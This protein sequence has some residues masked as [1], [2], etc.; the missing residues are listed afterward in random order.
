[1]IINSNDYT[2]KTLGIK[3]S[4]VSDHFTFT[5]CLDKDF[6]TTKR[7][8]LSEFAKLFDPLGWLSPTTF[9]LKSFLQIL[10]MD[11]LSWDETLSLNIL[12]QYGRFRHQ[13]KE[14]EKI[15]LERRVFAAP[16]SSSLELHVFC[17]A[18]TTAYA[19]FVYVREQMDDR[20]HTQMLTAK[21]RVAPI[22]TL[23]VP[24]LEI[25][26]ALLGAQLFQAVK[27]AIND[28][29]FPNPKVFAWTN[30]QVTLA[31]I[32]DIPRKWKTFVANRVTKIQSIIPS[33]NWKFVPTEDNP[34]DCASRGISADKLVNHQLW[35]KGPNW[36]RQDE[37][38]WPSLDVTPLYNASTDALAEVNSSAQLSLVLQHQQEDNRIL[39]PISRQSS[40]YRLVRVFA[41][42]KLFIQRLQA[43]IRRRSSNNHSQSQPA[44]DQSN[45]YLK[46]RAASIS[47]IEQHGNA[48]L[49]SSDN[50]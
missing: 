47:D 12:E 49:M 30:S 32:K 15:K 6:L 4:P 33:E 36:L 37:Q 25:C 13:L 38:F 34:A 3:W 14:L 22:K 16:F 8:I 26:A 43:R 10:W 21:T 45:T 11:K 7:K 35:W 42:V 23:C 27:E 40:M 41:Y 5:V 18:S 39:D 24:R 19:A 20:V 50:D 2:V 17:D 31:W 1:M 28:N 46:P 48:Q 29:R 44:I 9:Q